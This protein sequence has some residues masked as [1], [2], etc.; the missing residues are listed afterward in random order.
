MRLFAFAVSAL[1]AFTI[2]GHAVERDGFQWSARG[3]PLSVLRGFH[4]KGR[5]AAGQLIEIKGVN[6]EIHAEGT[7]GADVEIIAHKVA[8]HGDPGSVG[9]QLV[10]SAAGVTVCTVYPAHAG[11]DACLPG[12]HGRSAA[13]NNDV[14]IDFTVRVPA[15]VR[16]VGRTVNGGITATAIR[17]DTE[18]YTVNGPIRLSTSGAAQARTVNGSIVAALG[19]AFWSKTREF[20]TVNGAIELSLPP[21]ISADIRATTVNGGIST[22]FPLTAHSGIIG[23]RVS[24]TLGSGGRQLKL[25]T[26]NGSIRLHQKT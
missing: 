8:R 24:A 19:N 9:V 1:I 6:G 15:G 21:A 13:G 10:E 7:S 22:D 5:L 4:W 2:P 17:A 11:R 3:A 18:A 20:S 14:R 16:F 23:R 25:T 26:V 12:Q